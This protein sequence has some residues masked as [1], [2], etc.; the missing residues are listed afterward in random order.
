MNEGVLNQKIIRVMHHLRIWCHVSGLVTNTEKTITLL[1]HTWKNKRV[2]KLQIIFEGIDIK[3][4]YKTKFL[5]LHLSEDI[6]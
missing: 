1:C 4:K 6:K 3:C 5:C 2:I